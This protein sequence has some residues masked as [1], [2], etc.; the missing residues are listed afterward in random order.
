M[1]RRLPLQALFLAII[2]PVIA[3]STAGFGYAAYVRLYATILEGFDRKLA[4]LSSTTSVFI[5]TDA[6]LALLARSAAIKAAGGDPEQDPTYQ[7]YVLPMR[8]VRERAGLTFLYTQVL[9]SG[10]GRQ[11]VYVLDGTVGEGHSDLGAVDTIP[12]DDWDV[13]LRV[14]HDGAVAQT[15]IRQWEQWGLLKCGWAPMY[16][17]DG[18]IKAMAGAD[19]EIT[20]IRQ[21][22]YTVLLQTLG[23]GALALMLASAVSVRVARKLTQPLGEVRETALRIASGN[24]GVRCE[25]RTPREIGALGGALNALARVMETTVDAARPRMDGWRRLSADRALADR[26]ALPGCRTRQLALR[27]L[28]GPHA[29]G[30]VE[31]G[32]CTLLWVGRTEPDAIAARRTAR[33]IAHV[34]QQLLR[35]EPAGAAAELRRLLGGRVEA[36]AL[37]DRREWTVRIEG[38][39]LVAAA[40]GGGPL[41]PVLP[42][43][44]VAVIVPAGVS[45]PEG[46]LD[47]VTLADALAAAAGAAGAGV[48]AVVRRPA[49]VEPEEAV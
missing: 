4:A 30:F 28:P 8:E 27:V 17:A 37:I 22:T 12:E 44:A 46:A 21:K 23:T 20:V 7:K 42:P 34:A 33:D 35:R 13:A 48:V 15:A 39:A 10:E 36:C 43:G 32:P 18:T 9:K 49:A 14:V 11:C 6:T 3:V 41:P 19:V 38:T 25:V 29:S 1:R 47:P 16:G 40:A 31:E 2:T 45:L 26:L 5:D 24:Y